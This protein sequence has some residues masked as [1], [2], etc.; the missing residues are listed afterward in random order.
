MKLVEWTDEAGYKHLSLL[1]DTDPDRQAETGIPQ[2]PPSLDRLDWEGIKKD[3]HNQLV[4]MRLVDWTAV[5]KSG[6]GIT[7]AITSIIK[8]QIV[9]LYR[10]EEKENSNGK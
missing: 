6:N 5:Q 2:D 7:A 8:R 4:A 10:L 3:I 1:R 9:G